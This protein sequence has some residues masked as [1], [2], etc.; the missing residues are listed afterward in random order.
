MS[1]LSLSVKGTMY[2]SCLESFEPSA[3][4]FGWNILALP[5]R[6]FFSMEG[7]TEEVLDDST[8]KS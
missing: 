6:F 5:A 3:V 4:V 1:E 7:S 8:K 2:I